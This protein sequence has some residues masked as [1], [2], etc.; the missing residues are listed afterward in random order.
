V[1]KDGR[2]RSINRT[3]SKDYLNWADPV[4]LEPNVS[5]EHFYTSQ[6]HPYFLAPHIYV[7]APSSAWSKECQTAEYRT[8]EFR[9]EDT[10]PLFL[11]KFQSE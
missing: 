4:A 3:T 9:R 10:F 1:I 6:T 5:G 11:E 2:L 7:A 8:S